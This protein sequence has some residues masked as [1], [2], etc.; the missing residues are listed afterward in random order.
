MSN[1]TNDIKHRYFKRPLAIAIDTVVLAIVVGQHAILENKPTL[2]PTAYIVGP[3]QQVALHY[4]LQLSSIIVQCEPI[5]YFE[6][7]FLSKKIIVHFV[8]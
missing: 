8:I 2:L 1:T 4:K 6:M 5:A 7:L 3:F